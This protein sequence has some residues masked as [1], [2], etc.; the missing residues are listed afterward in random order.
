[1]N[2][3]AISHQHFSIHSSHSHTRKKRTTRTANAQRS[4]C[5][6]KSKRGS[7]RVYSACV[8]ELVL[9]SGSAIGR[10]TLDPLH[11]SEADFSDISSLGFISLDAWMLARRARASFMAFLDPAYGIIRPTFVRRP[12][13]FRH[14]VSTFV[15]LSAETQNLKSSFGWFGTLVD[16]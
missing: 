7:P 5:Q 6:Y 10:R 3:R 16:G 2:V 4:T 9:R 8:N 14:T 1:M 13:A 15:D 12:L 11:E